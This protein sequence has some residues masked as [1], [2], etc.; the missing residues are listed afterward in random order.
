MNKIFKNNTVSIV[1]LICLF[2][3]LVIIWS[4]FG[5]VS[6]FGKKIS[7]KDNYSI[8]LSDLS[9]AMLGGTANEISSP[10]INDKVSISDYRFIFNSPGDS[11]SYSFDVVNDNDYGVRLENIYNVDVVCK[12]KNGAVYSEVA[13][14]VCDNIVFDLRYTNTDTIVSV[15]DTI[16]PYDKVNLTLTI[17]YDASN[18]EAS[19]NENVEVSGVKTRLNYIRD[20]NARETIGK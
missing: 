13:K 2:T 6:G 5:N 1:V 15:N 9:G 4:A 16:K 3:F 8:H 17:I 10:E 7:V 18:I 12:D 20:N 11:A 14:K 19:F